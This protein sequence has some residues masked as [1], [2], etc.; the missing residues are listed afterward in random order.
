MRKKTMPA[1]KMGEFLADP[2]VNPMS[3]RH[4]E[5]EGQTG[6]TRRGIEAY[7]EGFLRVVKG[8]GE[9]LGAFQSLPF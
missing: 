1:Q 6:L 8:G 2:I 4:R 9:L 7:S 3:V 5:F